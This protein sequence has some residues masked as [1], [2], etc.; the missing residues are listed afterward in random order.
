[1]KEINDW[2]FKENISMKKLIE[3]SSLIFLKILFVIT[4]PSMSFA[5]TEGRLTLNLSGEDWKLVSASPGD[6][7][8]SGY[9]KDAF[10]TQNIIKAI[11][12]GDVNWDMMRAGKI[13]DIYEGK[14]L[15]KAYD[16]PRSEWWYQK[17][18]NLSQPWKGKKV[19]LKFEGVDYA[20]KIWLNG[21]FLIYHLGAFTPFSLDVSD[22]IKVGE[23]NTLTVFIE[24]GPEV[25]VNKIASQKF[26]WGMTSDFT[27]TYKYWKSWN[28]CG[29]DFGVGLLTMGIWKDVTLIASTDV[30]AENL[31][32]FPQTT[33][34]YKQATLNVKLNIASTDNCEIKLEYKAE[35]INA[36]APTKRAVQTAKLFKNK[37]L[38]NFSFNIESP[39]L[40]WPNGYGDQNLYRL[41][42]TV[43]DIKTDKILDEVISKFGVRE[44]KYLQ[45][46]NAP[47]YKTYNSYK[48]KGANNNKASIKAAAYTFE[49][50]KDIPIDNPPKFLT[51]INGRK[52]FLHGGNWV[53]A[54]LL[55][56]RPDRKELEHIIRM[57]QIANY[58]IFRMW[59]GGII[60]KEA[61]YDLCDEYGI[62]VIQEM[63]N[64]GPGPLET[65]EIVTIK[66]KEQ[67]E[68]MPLLINHPSV[69]RYGYGNELYKYRDFSPLERQFE[70]ICKEL[71]PTRVALGPDPVCEYQRHGEYTF[72]FAKDY[73]YFN[74]G[75]SA[76]GQ[77][78]PSN[79]V[80]WSEIGATS[81]S[82]EKTLRKIM[83]HLK[84]PFELN[85]T[86]MKWH[87]AF[88]ANGQSG[89]LVPEFY[90]TMFG[91]LPNLRTEVQVSQFAQSEAYRYINQSQFR[92][93]WHRSGVF[94]W[95]FN[96]N[97]SCAAVGSILEYYGYPKMALYYTRNSY[98]QIN[99]STKYKSMAIHPN[100]TLHIP[101][102][103][104]N[105]KTET[106][107]RC[108]LKTSIIDLQGKQH[109]SNTKDVTVNALRS[110]KID[111][112][113]YVIPRKSNN[114]VLLVRFD[115]MDKT[116]KSLSSETYTF[117]VIDAPKDSVNK[118]YLK[119]MLNAPK[120][121]LK[122]TITAQNSK[123]WGSEKMAVYKAS[124]KN[125]S[126][127]PSL[128]VQ[129]ISKYSPN[130]VY[131]KDNYIIL[132]P[133]EERNIDILVSSKV[134][135]TF[136]PTSVFVDSWNI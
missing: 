47:D 7:E 20:T 1:M 60:E 30:Y 107:E 6:G 53:P 11:V 33:S 19:M 83:P 131:F 71:D 52:I 37:N 136:S 96:E 54:D 85:D 27:N 59:G 42:I 48:D 23:E 66:E 25:I 40:W 132:F 112:V 24:Q 63:P 121:M 13:P 41:S 12:P 8:K 101:V 51:E 124:I 82:S 105:S 115:L 130:E 99:V 81:L 64:F 10:P 44:L 35:C 14:N 97:W 111:S 32:V 3:N 103:V 98:S 100:D 70:D 56:G 126:K 127:V 108:K 123:Q 106:F 4:I 26:A 39:A 75:L 62:M 94:I 110:H 84:Y 77:T 36:I 87:N 120:A 128:F 102:F 67:R 65:P 61:F 91:K 55:L 86:L 76:T 117:G 69:I 73:D 113:S 104:N 80:E 95:S 58:N 116:G 49:G 79:P 135:S 16:I 31:M 38:V 50:T 46:P 133:G 122:F 34:P 125:T 22:K 134:S 57:A 129:L 88:G 18:F 92:A 15:T 9:Y 5:Q 114:K 17:K 68:I 119:P 90:E 28:N 43:K 118:D 21:Q 72:N 2:K 74:K 93:K 45:N 89:W 78:G 109:Y 29:F